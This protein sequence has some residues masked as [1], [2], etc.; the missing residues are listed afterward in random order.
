VCHVIVYLT[1]ESKENSMGKSFSNSR[2]VTQTITEWWIITELTQNGKFT[3]FRY[4]IGMGNK[5]SFK[6]KFF[7]RHRIY[8]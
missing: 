6:W 2:S 3:L 7:L 1:T 5:L 8:R 4:E